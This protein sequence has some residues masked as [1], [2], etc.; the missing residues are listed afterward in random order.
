MYYNLYQY[1]LIKAIF[2][3]FNFEKMVF[4]SL[5]KSIIKT[6]GNHLRQSV[7]SANLLYSKIIIHFLRLAI[8]YHN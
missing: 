1:T 4:S 7:V 3:N 5:F 2:I 8:N 6:S